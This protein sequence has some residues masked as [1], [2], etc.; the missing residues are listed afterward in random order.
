MKIEVKND[1]DKLIKA[2]ILSD[3]MLEELNK[4]TTIAI[5]IKSAN[6]LPVYFE[7]L[8]ARRLKVDYLIIELKYKLKT[9]QT[10]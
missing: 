10:R 3:K 2:R 1:R 9:Y 4:H 8:L 5:K 6:K 7:S